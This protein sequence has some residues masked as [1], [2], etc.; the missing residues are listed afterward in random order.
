MAKIERNTIVNVLNKN[1]SKT[2][3][4][5]RKKITKLSSRHEKINSIEKNVNHD[6]IHMLTSHPLYSC[7]YTI[8]NSINSITPKFFSICLRTRT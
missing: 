8:T 5:I 1:M 7:Y 2:N 3:I 4:T 6:I